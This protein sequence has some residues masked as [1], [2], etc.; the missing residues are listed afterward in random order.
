MVWY[1]WNSKEVVTGVLVFSLASQ[2]ISGA[3]D[4]P[5]VEPML[6]GPLQASLDHLVM[7]TTVTGATTSI[8]R[9]PHIV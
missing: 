8:A 6:P 1:R 5:H 3:A 9:F 4:M 7:S 2:E